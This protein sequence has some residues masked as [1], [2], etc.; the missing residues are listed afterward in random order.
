MGNW[1][2]LNTS[3]GGSDILWSSVSTPEQI[4]TQWDDVAWQEP[5][6]IIYKPD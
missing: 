6:M 4:T 1:H 2:G 3:E 5:P